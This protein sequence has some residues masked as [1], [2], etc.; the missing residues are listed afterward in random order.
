[1]YWSHR[2]LK[3]DASQKLSGVSADATREGGVGGGSSVPAGR[4]ELFLV[5]AVQ[6]SMSSQSLAG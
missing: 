1:M 3:P 5:F 2:K 6:V 4:G